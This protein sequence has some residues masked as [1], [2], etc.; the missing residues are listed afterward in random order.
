ME[1]V[2]TRE[3]E[4][5]L[6]GHD[7]WTLGTTANPVILNATREAE[8]LVPDAGDRLLVIG[9]RALR[10]L[11]ASMEIKDYLYASGKIHVAD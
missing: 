1:P 2:A 8:A 4:L 5:W 11:T 7:D 10:R 6:I 3:Q 9:G